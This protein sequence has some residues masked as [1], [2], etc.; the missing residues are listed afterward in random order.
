MSARL[1]RP[2]R[3]GIAASP[4]LPGEAEGAREIVRYGGD[5]PVKV[6]AAQGLTTL[7]P[8]QPSSFKSAAP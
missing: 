1:A 3:A 2:R 5:R 8:R 6:A 7:S 4:W